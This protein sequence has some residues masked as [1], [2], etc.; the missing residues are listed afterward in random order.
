MARWGKI[1]THRNPAVVFFV[2]LL[3]VATT[4][5]F[6][7]PMAK[8]EPGDQN[9]YTNAAN[10][11][12][13]GTRIYRPEDK[14]AFTYPPFFALPFVPLAPL[15]E[16]VRRSVWY[17]LQ[18]WSVFELDQGCMIIM[19]LSSFVCFF[20]RSE[21]CNPVPRG[22][23]WPLWRKFLILVGVRDVAIVFPPC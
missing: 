13:A 7:M 6:V 8:D 22:A 23:C 15:S 5:A 17:F 9:V 2:I 20:R 12:T 1:V 16:P 10:R 18:G 11:L 4:L 14:M 21:S 3:V 19:V